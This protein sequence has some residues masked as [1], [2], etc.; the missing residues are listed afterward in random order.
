MPS[1][2]KTSATLTI[3]CDLTTT[4]YSL[5]Q[6]EKIFGTQPADTHTEAHDN[7]TKSFLSSFSDATERDEDTLWEKVNELKGYV[8]ITDV[9]YETEDNR[10]SFTVDVYHQDDTKK[11]EF[12][13]WLRSTNIFGNESGGKAP[14]VSNVDF[15]KPYKS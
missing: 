4:P 2:I 5:D 9:T 14:T 7:Y 13:T 3:D 11:T 1:Y 8:Y 6:L 12:E 10:M 15:H